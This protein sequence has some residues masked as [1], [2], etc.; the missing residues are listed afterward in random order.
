MVKSKVR[1]GALSIIAVSI[2]LIA[3]LGI[4]L[5]PALKEYL[6]PSEEEIQEEKVYPPIEAADGAGRNNGGLSLYSGY[7]LLYDLSNDKVLYSLNSDV[8]APPASLTKMMTVYTALLYIDDISDEIT[9]KYE[10]L[11]GLY[12]ANA[13]MAGL[14]ERDTVPIVDLLYCT[15]LPS[16]ADAANTLARA[17]CGSVDKFLIKMNETASSLEMYDSHFENVT[18]LDSDE[19]FTTANDLLKLMKAALKNDIFRKVICTDEY[20]TVP[21]SYYPDGIRLF[22]TLSTKFSAMELDRGPIIGGK[23]GYTENAGLC[24]ASLASIDG[25]EYLL[26]T[27]GAEGDGKSP[28]TN[29]LDA[30]YLYSRC[31]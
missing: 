13:S 19:H 26:I 16:G 28:Q 2:I 18:G 30:L 20:V 9:V 21:T 31:G 6:L 4:K 17:A 1:T 5:S 27:M 3:F 7:A 10:D 23:T 29:L 12:E 15:M 25:H 11:A 14:Q 8:T 24:L 22:S